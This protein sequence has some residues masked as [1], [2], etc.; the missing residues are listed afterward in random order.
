MKTHRV[1]TID[2]EMRFL[3]DKGSVYPFFLK[4]K[5]LVRKNRLLGRSAIYL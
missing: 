4:V 3:M 2:Y 1:D 5:F